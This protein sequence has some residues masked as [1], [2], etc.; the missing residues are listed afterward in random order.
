MYHGEEF[1]NQAEEK[2]KQIAQG[3]TPDNIE[4]IKLSDVTQEISI[5][6]LL[7]KVNFASSKGE[8][9]R[10]IQGKGVK[11]NDKLVEEINQKIELKEA[12]V[13]KFGKNKFVKIV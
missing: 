8:A 7:V 6:D 13:L 1:I 10:M 4:T 9:K 2:Y 11:V 12:V 3:R 5:C